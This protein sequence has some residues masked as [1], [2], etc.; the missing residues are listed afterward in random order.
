[1]NRKSHYSTLHLAMTAL[2]SDKIWGQSNGREHVGG[3]AVV[4]TILLSPLWWQC[5]PTNRV[6]DR[7]M[8]RLFFGPLWLQAPEGRAIIRTVELYSVP[9][10]VGQQWEL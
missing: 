3:V 10:W 5:T 1:M 2:W 4:T 6:A 9:Q 8:V 7:A